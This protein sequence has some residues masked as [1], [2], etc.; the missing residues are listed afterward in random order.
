MTGAVEPYPIRSRLTVRPRLVALIAVLLLTSPTIAAN[1]VRW[2][3]LPGK[4]V[5][6]V[7]LGMAPGE[8]RGILGEPASRENNRIWGYET[9]ARVRIE[10]HAG[11]V[12][13]I[14][15]WDP[16]AE[17]PDGLRVGS[18]QSAVVRALGGNPETRL[19]PSGVW[20]YSPLRGLAVFI[21]K[22]VAAAYT[23]MAPQSAV[24]TREPEQTRPSSPPV[25]SGATQAAPVIVIENVAH[26]VDRTV[27]ITG[28]VRNAGRIPRAYV[29]VTVTAKTFR[30][31][32]LDGKRVDAATSLRPGESRAFEVA[33]ERNL[34]ESYTVRVNRYHGQ[35]PGETVSSATGRISRSEYLSWA[36]EDLAYHVPRHYLSTSISRPVGRWGPQNWGANVGVSLSVAFFP[37]Y[38][39]VSTIVVRVLWTLLPKR[40]LSESGETQ[41]ALTP[42]HWSAQFN[43]ARPFEFNV[44][45]RAEVV[46]VIWTLNF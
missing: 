36:N 4:A 28:T 23:V 9:P 42:P 35:Q 33:I 44:I 2:L 37:E 15:T 45:E 39:K 12:H 21:E 27:T 26:K 30:G 17:T 16:R 5:G 11:R 38:A 34:W 43:L 24:T 41:L 40:G 3:V 14:T 32:T 29:D 31:T 18:P 6:P 13:T 22:G 19:T 7:I 20:V 46:Q 10:F 8:V 1:S 25:T